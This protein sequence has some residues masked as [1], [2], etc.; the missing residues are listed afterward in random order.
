M[1]FFPSN[2]PSFVIIGTQKAA[3][4]SLYNYLNQLSGLQGSKNKEIYYF[5]RELSYGKT[6][7]W[8]HNHFKSMSLIRDSIYFEATPNYLY[9][10]W[11]AER[12]Y[13]YNSKLKLIV[14]LRDPIERAFSAW[15]MYSNFF[16]RGEMYRFRKGLNPNEKNYIYEN[17]YK[18]RTQFP[19]FD[20]AVQIELSLI[21]NYPSIPEPSILRRGLYAEQLKRFFK[22]FDKSQIYVIGYTDLIESPKKIIS[23]LYFWITGFNKVNI[24]L[25]FEK[26][27]ANHYTNTISDATRL[28]LVE[29][30]AEDKSKVEKLV[31]KEFNW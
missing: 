18:G 1:T 17:L 6:L 21:N 7:N 25:K 8:Y 10:P 13:S 28:K 30:F 23:E 16:S 5:D 15:N 9:Y 2:S 14:V 19:S 3:T 20:E 29:F 24:D 11:V 27:N 31:E 4:T 26:R 22:Y 12:M